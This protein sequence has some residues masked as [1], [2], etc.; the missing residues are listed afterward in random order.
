MLKVKKL[1]SL[2]ICFVFIVGLIFTNLSFIRAA[3]AIYYSPNTNAPT[4]GI[5]GTKQT[6]VEE[7]MAANNRTGAVRPFSNNSFSVEPI[8]YLNQFQIRRTPQTTITVTKGTSST[9]PEYITY[10]NGTSD[11]NLT[12]DAKTNYKWFRIK[13][14]VPNVSVFTDNTAN[15][16]QIKIS[17]LR[18]FQTDDNGNN[19]KWLNIDMVRTVSKLEIFEPDSYSNENI[20]TGYRGYTNWVALGYDVCNVFYIGC[21]EVTVDN[22]FYLAG[23]NTP[24]NLKTNITCID[25]DADQYIS[26]KK[27]NIQKH[28]L[29]SNT[30]LWYNKYLSDRQ[31]IT[32]YDSPNIEYENSSNTAVGFI[33]SGTSIEYNFG[34][35]RTYAT[36][37]EQFIGTVNNMSGFTPVNPTKTIT[38]LDETN[39]KSNNIRSIGESWTYNIEQTI[40]EVNASNFTSFSFRDYI[41]GCLSLNQSDISIEATDGVNTVNATD[42]FDISLLYGSGDHA[43]KR[44]DVVLKS[45]YVTS[46]NSQFYKYQTYRLKIPVKVNGSTSSIASG[47]FLASMI[48]FSHINNERTKL[49]FTNKAYSYINNEQRTTNDVDTTVHLSTK[50]LDTPGLKITKTADKFEY[51]VGDKVHYTVEVSNTN[52]KADT[53]Y[54]TVKDDTLPNTM[55]LDSDSFEISGVSPLYWEHEVNGNNWQLTSK[56]NYALPYG[57][58]LKIEFDAIALKPSNSHLVNNTATAFAFG[59]GEHQAEAEVWVNSPKFNV[60][61][62]ADKTKF[63][64]G[65]TIKYTVEATNINEGTLAKANFEDLL[66]YSGILDRNSIK[67]MGDNTDITNDCSINVANNKISITTNHYLKNGGCELSNVRDSRRRGGYQSGIVP[68]SHNKITITYEVNLP[69]ANADDSQA[70][71]ITDHKTLN[72]TIKAIPYPVYEERDIKEDDTIPSGSDEAEESLTIN[73]PQLSIKKESNKEAYKVDKT[74]TY[75]LTVKQTKPNLIA[76][77]VVITDTFTNDSLSGITLNTNSIKVYLNDLDI[78]ALT[79]ISADNGRFTIITNKSISDRDE[80]KVTYNVKFNKTGYFN[81]MASAD[82]DNTPQVYDYNQ[83]EVQVNGLPMT[84]QE[85]NMLFLFIGLAI[86]GTITIVI[87][88]KK[89]KLI[90]K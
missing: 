27:G 85:R 82:A 22:Q 8:Y 53:A 48:R 23:T 20:R 87:V 32:R 78:T 26:F 19:G 38:D 58:I 74:G 34:R 28:Y 51:Q 25:V 66:E 5:S 7:W 59:V 13:R 77:N 83:V 81:N 76:R 60:T 56:G 84:G 45:S 29:T 10:D 12:T 89:R 54:F 43:S 90:T 64:L 16:I 49:N 88:R 71:L 63:N 41:D 33:L 67:V 39:V 55:Q 62:V 15:N 86:I 80:I 46:L 44:V 47:S 4:Y 61:K 6:G 31:N 69:S 68:R 72:N 24:V 65:D 3:D 2:M 30:S 14:A 21:K 70:I 57:T 36:N 17:N 18:I 52:D 11:L 35:N 9:A 75:T 50:A 79:L 1:I 40:P 37:Q 73:D 42:W